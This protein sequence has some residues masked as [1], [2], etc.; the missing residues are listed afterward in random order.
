MLTTFSTL[1]AA[2]GR[3][4]GVLSVHVPDDWLQ[5][6]SLFGGLQAALAVETMRTLVPDVPLRVLQ[7]T[8]VGPVGGGLVTVSARVLRAGKNVMHVEAR[9]G[10]DAVFIGIFGQNRPSVVGITLEEPPRPSPTA[11][12]RT[13]PF[14][15]GVTPNFTQ[16]Y[17]A[18][19]RRG[20]TP[21]TATPSPDPYLELTVQDDG[22]FTEAHL[23]ALADFIPPIALSYLR[24]PAP[25]S[26]VTWMLELLRYDFA[27]QPMSGWV[28]DGRLLAAKDGYTSQTV[29]VIAPD[30]TPAA[31]SRQSMLVFG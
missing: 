23:I 25:G 8:F 17:A 15:P 2:A 27:A 5:G 11:S 26:S 16:H 1:L 12:P 13:L 9:L 7:T 20:A 22:P 30:G 3:S 10:D 24:V 21:F 14:I 19:W 4:P 31:L 29:T 18:T 28:I 6:R